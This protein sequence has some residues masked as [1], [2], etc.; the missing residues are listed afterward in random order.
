[1]KTKN[2]MLLILNI[3]M[4]SFHTV[5]KLRKKNPHKQSQTLVKVKQVKPG[6]NLQTKQIPPT[7]FLLFLVFRQENHR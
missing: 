2:V 1:M 4:E 7:Q 5:P 6:N 3:M